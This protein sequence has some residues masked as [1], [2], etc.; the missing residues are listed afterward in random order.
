MFGLPGNPVSSLVCFE[1]FVR[2]A[3]ARLAGRN[4][5]SKEI[6]A[7]L[8]TVFA[9]RG[10]RPTYHP[11]RLELTDGAFRVTPVAWKGSADLAGLVHANAL[12]HFPGGER[13]YTPGEIVRVHPFSEPPY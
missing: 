2:P 3:L 10:D 6:P 5:E 1:L 13:D 12:A 11:A 4:D 9:Q 8:T 7:A